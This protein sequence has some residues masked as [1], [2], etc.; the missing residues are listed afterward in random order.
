VSLPIFRGK[1][2]AARKQ[3]A[4]L[5]ES[6]EQRKEGLKNQLSAELEAALFEV[7]EAQAMLQLYRRQEESSVQVLNLFFP[8]TEMQLQILRRCCG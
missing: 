6:Y 3:A 1:Y 5:A 8:H 2:K 4:F 7:R